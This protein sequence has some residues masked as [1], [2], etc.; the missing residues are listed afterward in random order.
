MNCD[1]T[2][3]EPIVIVNKLPDNMLEDIQTT[4]SNVLDVSP[5]VH[6]IRWV[7]D[8]SYF[9]EDEGVKK[10]MREGAYIVEFSYK[11][12]DEFQRIVLADA[13]IKR[14]GWLWRRETMMYRFFKDVLC[15]E[16]WHLYPVVWG[17]TDP[18]FDRA[19]DYGIHGIYGEDNYLQ[20]RKKTRKCS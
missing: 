16:R 13:E 2:L 19:S 6:S 14:K 18:L 20:F 10:E 7:Y 11:S 1:D 4:L 12:K 15:H 17:E 5:T 9:E 8:F 3:D